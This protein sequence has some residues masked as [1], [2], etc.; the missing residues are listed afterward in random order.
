MRIVEGR[1]SKKTDMN[2]VLCRWFVLYVIVIFGLQVCL[3]MTHLIW[4]IKS[5]WNNL[6]YS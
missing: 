5:A 2:V 1:L 4:V 3:R 6:M